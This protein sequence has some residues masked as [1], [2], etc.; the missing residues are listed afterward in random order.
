MLQPH[1]SRLLLPHCPLPWSLP[2]LLWCLRFPYYQN[3][4]LSWNTS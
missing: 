3:H 2:E 4:M 1:C